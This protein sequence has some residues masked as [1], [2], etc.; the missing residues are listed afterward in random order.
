MGRLG[1]KVSILLLP[2]VPVSSDPNFFQF[3]CPY[4]GTCKAGT[5]A[6]AVCS[7]FRIFAGK[8]IENGKKIGS[9]RLGDE[10]DASPQGKL[11]HF[12]GLPFG[13]AR[14]GHQD[15]ANP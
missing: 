5:K 7:G 15:K 1:D 12:G 13:V 4:M 9:V 8:E 11:R 6:V 2:L 10:E 14:R 3:V